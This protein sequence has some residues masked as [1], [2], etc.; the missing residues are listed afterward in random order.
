MNDDMVDR[1]MRH[2]A[3]LT[4]GCVGE[5]EEQAA[6]KSQEA[7]KEALVPHGVQYAASLLSDP[8]MKSMGSQHVWQGVWLMAASWIAGVLNAV[9]GG[10]SFL[11]FPALLGMGVMPI[12]ANATNTVALWP[13]QLTSIAGYREDLHANARLLIPVTICACV[14]GLAGAVVLLHTGQGTFLRLVPWLL[15]A[16]ALLFAASGP[17]ARWLA[18]RA[19]DRGHS[20]RPNYVALCAS[21]VFVCAY[22]GYFGAGAGFLIMSALAIFGIESI[23]EINALKVVATTVA[24]GTAVVTFVIGRQIVWHECLLMMLTAA[25]GG[26]IGARYSRR[27]DPR[28]MR[29]L[30]VVLGLGMSAYF[31]VRAY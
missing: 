17:I 18:A 10:G 12:Q 31:F 4:T 6:G 3:G 30:V 21:L 1:S 7:N 27:L 22:I 28:V 8:T 16:A 13:G 25:F 26:Y 2:C 11:S 19:I 9:A 5:S 14:G 20:G 29:A 23:R 15:L 24:N